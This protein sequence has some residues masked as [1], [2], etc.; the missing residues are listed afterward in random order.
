M[1]MGGGRRRFGQRANTR[2][3]PNQ[4][5]ADDGKGL[6]HRAPIS[7]LGTGYH[8]LRKRKKG[9][10]NN[11]GRTSKIRSWVGGFGLSY[12]YQGGLRAWKEVQHGRS[13]RPQL[14]SILFAQ[15][16]YSSGP[17]P[18]S[19]SSKWRGK[20]SRGPCPGTYLP[21]YLP[22]AS[23]CLGTFLKIARNMDGNWTQYSGPQHGSMALKIDGIQPGV[24]NRLDIK[25]FIHRQGQSHLGVCFSFRRPTQADRL[26]ALHAVSKISEVKDAFRAPA[27]P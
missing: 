26:P 5:P 1:T 14:P 21:T 17:I 4:P 13:P 9:T 27:K 24:S 25:S 7:R 16:T 18:I 10:K 23:T 6:G 22:K 11:F 2:S 15:T 20:D 3:R 12:D 19:A 8:D